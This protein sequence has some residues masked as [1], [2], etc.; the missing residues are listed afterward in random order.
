MGLMQPLANTYLS[1]PDPY[2][3]GLADDNLMLAHRCVS[4]IR[5]FATIEVKNTIGLIQPLVVAAIGLIQPLVFHNGH[6]MLPTPHW[7][8]ATLRR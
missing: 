7:T 6:P 4:T 1:D 5:C 8:F 2:L 3:P